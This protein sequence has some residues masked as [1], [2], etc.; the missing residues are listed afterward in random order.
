MF[1]P[2]RWLQFQLGADTLAVH[3]ALE[4]LG[5]ALWRGYGTQ[6]QQ[7]LLEDRLTEHATPQRDLFDPDDPCP[8]L[9][10][11]GGRCGP[12]QTLPPL[13]SPCAGV[14]KTPFNGLIA[15]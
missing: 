7:L 10:T 4:V 5:D 9:T 11:C 2:A 13:R 8:F 15:N 14:P 12:P 1:T 3:E 6:M